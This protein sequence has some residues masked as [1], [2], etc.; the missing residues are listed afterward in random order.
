[1]ARRGQHKRSGGRLDGLVGRH[2]AGAALHT[3]NIARTNRIEPQL[4]R[5]AVRH[6]VMNRHRQ[7]MVVRVEPQ[8]A[9]APQRRIGSQVERRECILVGQHRSANERI[10][11]R[12]QVDHGQFDRNICIDP[13]ARHGAVTR[14]EP[15]AQRRMHGRDIREGRTQ[16]IDV[17]RAAHPQRDRNVVRGAVRLR[18]P[19]EPQAELRRRQR[20]HAMCIRFGDGHARC[21]RTGVRRARRIGNLQRILRE[22][23]RLEQRAH[24]HVAAEPFG[25]AR[26]DAYGGERM[27]AEIEKVIATAHALEI[28]HVAPD[29]RKRGFVAVV[30]RFVCTFDAYRRRQPCAVDLAVRVARQRV[31][32]DQL[33]GHHVIGQRAA[34]VRVERRGFDRL[35]GR[36]CVGGQFDISDELR[37]CALPVH[38]RAGFPHGLVRGKLGLDL[39]EFD[40]QP[41]Q[42]HLVVDA[43]DEVEHAIRAAPHEVARAVQPRARRAVRIGHEALGRQCRAVEI[44][45]RDADPLAAQVQLADHADRQRMQP[46]VEHVRG[47]CTNQRADRQVRGVAEHREIVAGPEHPQRRRDDRLGRAVAVDHAHVRQ[48][49]AQHRERLARRR[50]A[51]DRQRTQRRRCAMRERPFGELRGAAGRHVGHRH[52]VADHHRAGLRGRPQHVGRHRHGGARHVLRKPAFVRAVEV[53]RLEQQEHVVL[54][55]A[56]ALGDRR[57]MQRERRMVDDHT[58]RL[59]GRARRVD[60][61]GRVARQHVRQHDVRGFVEGIDFIGAPEAQIRQFGQR[62]G[63]RAVGQYVR[64]VRVADDLREPFARM[65]GVERHER[66]ARLQHRDQRDE[67]VDRALQRDADAH[68][69]PNAGRHQVACQ[70]RRARIDFTARQRAIDIGDAACVGPCVSMRGDAGM[71]GHERFSRGCACR[72]V[73]REELLALSGG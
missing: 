51:A 44:T 8:H 72:C 28:Q 9:R 16:R 43:A 14:D 5:F 33:R 73:P 56:V 48:R 7:H 3:R 64:D 62:R 2:G 24:R 34:Q 4:D 20:P 40:A 49:A 30:R 29:R 15:R 18:A 38:D 67:Q 6:D 69:R 53:D 1:M 27:A 68:F 36:P 39:A 13:L 23:R 58:L 26:R 22:H 63:A 50:L 12:R 57:A 55:R 41:A 61:I 10:G 45:A 66:G 35:R 21:R 59:A 19:Q 65:R 42:F 25:H 71:H 60:R 52:A 32:H 70:A 54:A 47:A 46:F 11:L 31:E 17:E 37:Q